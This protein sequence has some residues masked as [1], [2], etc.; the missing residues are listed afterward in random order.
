LTKNEKREIYI[1][2]IL[3]AHGEGGGKL[4]FPIIWRVNMDRERIIDSLKYVRTQ[5][6]LERG[7]D[8]SGVIALENAITIIKEEQAVIHQIDKIRKE[9]SDLE[10]QMLRGYIY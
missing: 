6:I 4:P 10:E 2:N 7:S 1:S 9:L 3:N 5:L 8:F